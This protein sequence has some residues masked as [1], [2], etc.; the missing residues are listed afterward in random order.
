MSLMKVVVVGIKASKASK[1]RVP[2]PP[3]R[4]PLGM[5]DRVPLSALVK[6]HGA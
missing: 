6:E 1:P 4:S 3:R 2:P 5:K